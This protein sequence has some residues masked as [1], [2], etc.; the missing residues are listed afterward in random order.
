MPRVKLPKQQ[1]NEIRVW[2]EHRRQ[3]NK[4]QHRIK[5]YNLPIQCT[6]YLHLAEVNENTVRMEENHVKQ[7]AE[8]E[9]VTEQLKAGDLLS[10]VRKMNN[11]CT[12]VC[13]SVRNELIEH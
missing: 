4:Q 13:E 12:K 10:W 9:D 6:L 3:F 5:Y 1:H 11:I 8:Q 2:G 7:L